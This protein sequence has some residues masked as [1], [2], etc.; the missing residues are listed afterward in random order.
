MSKPKNSKNRQTRPVT[1]RRRREER[2]RRKYAPKATP[3]P[4]CATGKRRFID[5][6]TAEYVIQVIRYRGEDTGQG[7]PER[8]YECGLCGGWHLT[9]QPLRKPRNMP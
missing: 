2:R 4:Q 6:A 3:E 8:A 7:K 9:S 5:R 1:P